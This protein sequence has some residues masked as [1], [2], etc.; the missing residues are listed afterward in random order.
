MKSETMG[1]LNESYLYEGASFD[2]SYS[3][4]KPVAVDLAGRYVRM[5]STDHSLGNYG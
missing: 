3:A 1:Y 4:G 2:R 5:Y